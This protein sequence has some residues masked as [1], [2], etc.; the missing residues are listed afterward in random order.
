MVMKFLLK[1]AS[2]LPLCLFMAACSEDET[3]PF[4]TIYGVVVDAESTEP[5]QGAKI[6]LTPSGKSTV[7]GN[8]G[9]YEL[10]DLEPGQY[11][12]TAQAAG[13]RS[14]LKNVTVVAGER[15]MGD[16]SL[17][18]IAANSRLGVDKDVLPFSKTV[19]SQTLNIQ[20][21]GNAGDLEWTIT[22]MPSWISVSPEQG[23]TAMG[24]SSAVQVSINGT[25]PGNAS[26]SLLVNAE[27]E[28]ISVILTVDA[29]G[30]SGNGEGNGGQQPE[31]G[32]VTNGLYAYYKFEGDFDDASGNGVHGNGINNPSFAD[33][34]KSGTR[35]VKFSRSDKS[36][37]SVAD[38]I[39]DSETLTISFWAKDLSDG[40]LFYL[41]SSNGNEPMFSLT[42]SNGALK[43]VVT[44]SN[45][46]YQLGN[47]PAFLHASLADGKWHHIALTSDFNNLDYATITTT[48]YI[49][50]RKADVV[51]EEANPFSEN[52]GSQSSYGTGTKFVLGGE[53]QVRSQTKANATNMSIDNFR[54]YDTR[55][56][57]D[58]EIR[59][60]YDFER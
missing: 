1:W 33:G 43:F 3:N 22:G 54:V 55:L 49:D 41:L 25:V 28:S 24:K 23:V 46:E 37:F 5:L 19:T 16:I 21:L 10:V 12:V 31:A 50:G 39:L 45:V 4:G 17:Q 52:G 60:I 38:P 34:V 26:S 6:T 32:D 35:A 7:T 8:D 58:A 47:C 36:S 13:F 20:N 57:S 44:R 48:L 11:K 53:L 18:K 40:N 27:G 14:S 51:T 29:D 59:Q 9:S 42:M 15:A 2:L 30:S 56:L